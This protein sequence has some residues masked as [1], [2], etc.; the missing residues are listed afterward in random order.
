MEI[1]LKKLNLNLKNCKKIK[2]NLYGRFP[3]GT[4]VSQMSSL[5]LNVALIE[6][7]NTVRLSTQICMN[8]LLFPC[9]LSH[10]ESL[11]HAVLLR[12]SQSN[13]FQLKT[14]L[15]LINKSK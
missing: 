7:R 9:Y 1:F 4:W 14:T 13:L 10:I 15:H 3:R 5:L 2:T 8:H 6:V 12:T 11:Y